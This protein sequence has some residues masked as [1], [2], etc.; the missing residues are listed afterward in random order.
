M[1]SKAVVVVNHIT[2]FV[3]IVNHFWVLKCL[4]MLHTIF[5]VMPFL[6]I[7]HFPYVVMNII[8][9]SGSFMPTKW[10][11]IPSSSTCRAC[12]SPI[13]LPMKCEMMASPGTNYRY[14]WLGPLQRYLFSATQQWPQDQ[15]THYQE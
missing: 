7:A 1:H 11:L 15:R 10:N 9:Q 6:Y 2:I 13:S 8:T 3:V 4:N 5:Q 12:N 14:F